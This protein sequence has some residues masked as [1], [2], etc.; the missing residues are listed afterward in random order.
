MKKSIVIILLAAVIISCN[1][2]DKNSEFTN[3]EFTLIA[4]DNLYGN[5]AEGIV[6]QNLII[7]NQ[8]AWN[9]LIAQMNTVNNVSDN[10]TETDLNFS[11]HTIIAVFDEVKGNG[12]YSLEL[13]IRSNSENIIV[14][15]TDL[16]PEGNATTVMTQ[17][18][19]IAKIQNSDLPIL[20][21]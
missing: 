2:N 3:V 18:F 15:V 14:K 17:P 21:E 13:H 9:D 11:E 5:G 12:G 6:E 8:T 1:S 4:Q 10:F 7:S 19:Y 16:V 20:F